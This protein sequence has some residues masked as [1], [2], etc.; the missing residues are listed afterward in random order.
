MENSYIWHTYDRAPQ[1]LVRVLV[2]SPRKKAYTT[3][4]FF[5]PY[6]AITFSLLS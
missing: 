3:F 1:A 2:R 5:N 4:T 6:G